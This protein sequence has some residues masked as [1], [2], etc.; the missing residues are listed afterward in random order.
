M[1]CFEALPHSL[2]I[3]NGVLGGVNIKTPDGATQTLTADQLLVFFGLH[4]KLGPIA[5][6]GLALEKR[7]LRVDTE[8]FQTSPPGVYAVGDINTYPGKEEAHPLGLPRGGARGVC[9]PASAVSAEEAVPAVH[10]HEPGDAPAPRRTGLKARPHGPAAGRSTGAHR[11]EA[12]EVNLFRGEPRW[13]PQVFSGRVLGQAL[14]AAA[15]AVKAARVVHSLHAYFLRRG[16]PTRRSL[17]GRPRPRWP[18]LLQP[19]R[20]RDQHGEQIFNMAACSR[21]PR[22]A[23]ITRSTCRNAA[24][25]DLSDY[26]G[27]PAD[28][29]ASARAR[30]PLLSS[31]GRLNF[32]VQP[33]DYLRPRLNCRAPD[34]VSRRGQAPEDDAAPAPAAVSD[35][36]SSIPP[37]CRTAPRSCARAS[38]RASTMR[39]VH[40]PLRVDDWLLYAMEGGRFRGARLLRASVFARRAPG[41]QRRRE[42]LVRVV[43][44]ASAR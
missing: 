41:G 8:K 42:G 27:P 20:G 10:D 34:V 2:L 39:W 28:A 3:E 18:Q 35:S 13:Q 9:D 7:V 11:L 22:R 24:T 5:E 19:A 4:P 29:G 31:R 32:A 44:H 40:R 16:D 36:S 33:I 12:L 25:A 17:P 23:S 26:T 1:R 30:A 37:R 38:S 15:R 21:R 14:S 43:K 6:W